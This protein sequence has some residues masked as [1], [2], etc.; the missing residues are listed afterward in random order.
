LFT[1]FSSKQFVGNQIVSTPISLTT[2]TTLRVFLG[3][4]AVKTTSGFSGTSFN[5]G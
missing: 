3:A 5:E 4:K 2:G 1:A